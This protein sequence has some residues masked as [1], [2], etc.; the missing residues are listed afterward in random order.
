MADFRSLES[1]NAALAE[2]FTKWIFQE[3]GVV[4][5]VSTHH[6]RDSETDPREQYTKK[7]PLVRHLTSHRYLAFLANGD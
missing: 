4:K 7:D 6:H 5:V 1:G 2:D 3:T